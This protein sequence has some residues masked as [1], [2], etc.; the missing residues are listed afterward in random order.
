MSDSVLNT[1]TQRLG[2]HHLGHHSDDTDGTENYG[3]FGWLRGMKERAL[4]LEFRSKDGNVFALG[5]TWLEKI[6]F[7]PSDG[8]TLRFTGQTIRIVGR[9]L[10]AEARPNVVLL[11]GLL[12]H[13]VP[14]IQQADSATAMLADRQAVVIERIDLGN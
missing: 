10:N 1:F 14:W 2:K 3:A 12:R 8:I 4:F 11:N 5:Y 6:S 13:K 9:N 7:N